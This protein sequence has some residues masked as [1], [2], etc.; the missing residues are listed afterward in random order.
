MITTLDLSC[1]VVTEYLDRDLSADRRGRI[2]MM[3]CKR[4]VRYRT[5]LY[6]VQRGVGPEFDDN[7]RVWYIS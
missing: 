7:L 4:P 1:H 5:V 6:R 2:L 3:T